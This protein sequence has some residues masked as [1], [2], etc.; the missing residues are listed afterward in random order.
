MAVAVK[1]RSSSPTSSRNV[2]AA[3]RAGGKKRSKSGWDLKSILVAVVLFLV[4]RTFLIEAY[5]IPSGSM[6]PTLLVGDFLFVNKAIYG[7]HVP[8][9]HVNLPGY[10]EPQRGGIVIYESPDQSRLPAGIRMPNDLTPIV[11]KRLVGLPGDTIYMRDG[12]LYIDGMAQ[13][14]GWG[15]A[16][17]PPGYEDTP[18]PVF[19]WQNQYALRSSRF[20]SAPAHPSH[21]N[22]GPLVIPPGHYMS[23]GDNRYDSVD[24]RYYG[25][26]PRENVRGKPLFIYLSVDTD[27]WRIRWNRIGKSVH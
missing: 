9:T 6:E 21:D 5:H 11:V 22:W 20:G 13:R 26:V 17:R 3:A 19:D 7:A 15:A 10:A 1:K 14:Q 8:F 12:L 16:P 25:F 4:I 2:V 27:D 18:D 23:L 24:A